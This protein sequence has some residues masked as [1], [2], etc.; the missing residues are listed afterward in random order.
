MEKG[1]MRLE[2]NISLVKDN[3]KEREEIDLPDYKVEIKNINSFRFLDKAINSE[4]ARQ[5]ELMAKGIRIYQETRGFNETLGT[6]ISQ[7][8][9]E[10]AKDYRY[11]PEPDIPP[12]ML[13]EKEIENI[14]N[15]L[16]ELPAKKQKRFEEK[17]K[18][19]AYYSTI[20]TSTPSIA[21]YFEKA[22]NLGEKEGISVSLIADVIV[23]KKFNEKYPEPASLIIKLRQLSRIEFSKEEE[24]SKT[25]D[26][27][28]SQEE[29]AVKDFRQGKGQ[30]I[31]F[32]LAKVQKELNGKANPKA[33]LRI[34]T[35]K[36]KN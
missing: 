9:K 12:I 21:E 33:I 4:I 10:E 28:I 5:E 23:N 36:L 3:Q 14:K 30:V 24:V 2:A 8:G 11:F 20:L 1:S 32:L 27:I 29:K 18:I 31:G 7:R 17:F 34:L 25:V 35:E 26:N 15:S 13:T 22:I 6:T 16:P 19:S